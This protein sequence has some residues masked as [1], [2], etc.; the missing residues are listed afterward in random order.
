MTEKVLFSWSGGK[1][2]AIA[3]YKIQRNQDY[4]IL[5]LFTTVTKDY[6]RISMHGVRRILLQKQVECMGLSLHE[7]FIPRNGSNEEYDS[8]MKEEMIRFR[9]KGISS[10]V[11]GD[12]FLEDVKN[13]RERNLSEVAMKGIFPIWNSDT[14]DLAKDFIAS[15]FKAVV[16]CVDSKALDEK[17]VGKILD[18][19][20][21][22]E[23]PS[24]VDPC[25]ENGEFHSFVFDGP[26]FKQAVKFKKGEVLL[27]DN[28]F[29][30][31]DLTPA[32]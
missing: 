21:L 7:V 3:L 26:I 31:C 27:R 20:F 6:D 10:V 4:K 1:D 32:D 22:S 28:R 16:T 12:I 2:S 8:I 23:L 11:F 25:G 19:H 13:Y 5:A 14:A 17:F 9:E 18:E 30:Y 24:N 15:G 29:Y